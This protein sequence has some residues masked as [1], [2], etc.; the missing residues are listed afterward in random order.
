MEFSESVL[1]AGSNSRTED[2]IH[3]LTLP[4]NYAHS[5]NSVID[6]DV[7]TIVSSTAKVGNS[8]GGNI[9]KSNPF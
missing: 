8:S 6:E 5:T 3:A 7:S 1:G 9:S 2:N 4:K